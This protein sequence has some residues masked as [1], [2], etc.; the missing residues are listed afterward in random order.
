MSSDSTVFAGTLLAA[1]GALVA[2]YSR[3]RLEFDLPISLLTVAL[4]AG[5]TP[6]SAAI[7]PPG[8]ALDVLF[9]AGLSLLTYFVAR[10][11][12]HRR[13]LAVVLIVL[14]SL[15]GVFG[16]PAPAPTTLFSP[17]HG[18]LAA[19]P[20]VYIALIGTLA[21]ARTRWPECIGALS[22]LALC[23]LF[24]SS[25][26]PSLALLAPGLSVVID[27]ARR[28]PLLA[29]A[30]L[31]LGAVVWN[32]WLMVQ[33]T[34]GL[35]PKDAPLSFATMVRQQ[36]DVHT[37]APYVYPFAFPGNLLLAWREGVPLRHYD[38]LSSVPRRE[39]VEVRLDRAADRLLID[40]WGPTGTNAAGPFRR[41]AATTARL[42]IPLAPQPRATSVSVLV[43]STGGAA[44]IRVAIN[45]RDIGTF[46]AP[47]G[48]TLEGKL[49]IAADDVGRVLRAGYNQV[50]ITSS[51][52]VAVHRVRISPAT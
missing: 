15:V 42:I 48:V 29:A 38:E 8:R 47:A 26:L 52:D 13:W 10:S 9:L 40:G 6:L 24:N 2:L 39:S 21:T 7:F 18:F 43:T 14:T 51:G 3:L 49:E 16:P 32:Y 5:A 36:A 28:R 30:P 17:P 27:W 20:V 46:H 45:Q 1:A 19:T 12:S 44:E 11:Q 25:L 35:I 22:A 31:I 23:P 4:I 34:G 37:R 41:I 33:Y 50:S